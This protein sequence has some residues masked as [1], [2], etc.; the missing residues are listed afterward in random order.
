MTTDARGK[1]AKEWFAD[2]RAANG[3]LQREYE[4]LA[5]QFM[6]VRAAVQ[7]RKRY[8]E[9]D[10]LPEGRV[11]L[12]PRM[13][14]VHAPRCASG[15]GAI[16]CICGATWTINSRFQEGDPEVAWDLLEDALPPPLSERYGYAHREVPQDRLFP[17]EYVVSL[18]AQA[19][20]DGA[21][22]AN[23]MDAGS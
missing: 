10:P 16:E 7:L 4:R 23:R 1:S 17:R 2:R 14:R 18:V 6:A 20:H 11:F 22:R 13:Q 12:Y 15:V 8:V 5:P 21:A 3:E 19:Y 9:Q